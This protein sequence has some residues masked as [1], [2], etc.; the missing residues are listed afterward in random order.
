MF[1][2]RFLKALFRGRP[3][4]GY[5]I[6]GFWGQ[7]KHFNKDNVQIGYTIKGF[8]G[9]RKRYDMDGNLKSVSWRNFWGGYNTYDAEGN[10]IRRSYRNFWG[11]YNTYNRDGKKIQESY[12]NFWEGLTHY[13]VENPDT[14]ET[15]T[16]EKRTALK[17]SVRKT[18]NSHP[19]PSNQHPITSDVK[20]DIP[21][22]KEKSSMP[23]SGEW[24]FYAKSETRT[25][26]TEKQKE[27][28]H[29]GVDVVSCAKNVTCTSTEKRNLNKDA[30]Y[31]PSINECMKDKEIMQYTRLLV[32]KYKQFAEFPAI[33]Y[34]DGN[35]VKVEPLQVGVNP[36]EFS[37]SEIEKA[38]EEKVADMDM[39]VIDDEF[40]S[41][42]VSGVGREFKD[43]LPEYLFSGSDIYRI[44]YVLD[45]G[46]VVTE[47][48]MEE[49]R[50]LNES[51]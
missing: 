4:S 19:L 29:T 6:R 15:F 37:V 38:Q 48:S 39:S 43:L 33:A 44:Q 42:I 16:V 51:I 36:F 10:L 41:C 50:K 23:T 13:D 2:V 5:S 26:Y 28:A 12:R 1:L 21:V 31:Y 25:E 47:K 3:K 18:S 8:W 34:L 9:Q 45:C 49:L 11:G 40:L 14:Y 22:S 30:R 27:D 24:D 20:C 17:T 46:M 7:I 35:K 32:F